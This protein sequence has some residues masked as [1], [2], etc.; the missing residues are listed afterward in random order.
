MKRLT[1]MLAAASATVL[2]ACDGT[3]TP[4]DT[5]PTS[6]AAPPGAEDAADVADAAKPALTSEGRLE[7]VLAGQPEDVRARYPYRN[8]A[9]TLAF[10]GIEPG[11]TVIEALPGGGW[12]SKILLA[13][14]GPDGKLIGAQYPDGLWAKLR[15]DDAE[16]A[17]QRI[18]A[19]AN[20]PVTASE[21]AVPGAAEIGSYSMTAAP[22]ALAGTADAVLF[23]RALHNIHRFNAETGWMDAAIAEAFDLLKP[24]GV[25]GVVQHRAPESNADE[26]ASGRAGYL[27]QSRIIEAF[28]AAG[29]VLDA[30]SELNANPDDKPGE[31]DIV[32]RL[33]PSLATTEEGTPERA[34]MEAIGESDRM[35]LRFVKPQ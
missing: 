11:M 1:L 15:P 26:W 3:T 8:P 31:T 19:S 2:A 30:T 5:T 20:W 21:W 29:F 32:W 22:E 33:P 7:A 14:V 13:Y 4:A 10:F 18:E 9:E 24:G 12:Y 35:T 6:A 17:A 16:W 23:I 27:K 34:A 25:V 28:E